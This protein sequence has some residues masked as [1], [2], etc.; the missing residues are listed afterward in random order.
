MFYFLFTRVLHLG[1]QLGWYTACPFN[2]YRWRA[3][4]GRM[5]HGEV[6]SIGQFH[7][8]LVISLRPCVRVRPLREPLSVHPHPSRRPPLHYQCTAEDTHRVFRP[9]RRLRR[10]RQRQGPQDRALPKP[11]YGMYIRLNCNFSSKHRH[12]SCRSKAASEV[13]PVPKLLEKLLPRYVLSAPR[14]SKSR[15]IASYSFQA[16]S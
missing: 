6:T 10:R 5:N 8:L 9:R 13:A 11:H 14:S 16:A 4:I 1:C 15:T 2:Q 3:G 7:G 12:W